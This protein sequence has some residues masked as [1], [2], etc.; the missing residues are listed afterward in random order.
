MFQSLQKVKEFS[1]KENLRVV[2][3]KKMLKEALLRI[4][5]TKDINAVK[6]N[7]LCLEAEVNR[8]T[9]YRHYETPYDILAE[10]EED[11]IH[12][13]FTFNFTSDTD[14]LCELKNACRYIY[15][16]KKI[17][18]ILFR[19]HTDVSMQRKMND[20]YRHVL[21]AKERSI[22]YSAIDDDTAKIIAALV[23]GGCYCM[24][25]Q[26]IMDDIP[27]AP[28]EIAEIVFRIMR[29]PSQED[30]I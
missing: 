21:N 11:M 26:W 18:K 6:I 23:G 5:E 12:E 13:M 7:E 29:R 9:F 8:A 17:V 22:K 14:V 24:L 16:N 20:I 25:R 15:E 1:M 10:I 30:F 4:L 3:T 19:C 27:K 28:D 2:I